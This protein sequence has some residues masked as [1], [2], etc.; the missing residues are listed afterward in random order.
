MRFAFV[1]LSGEQHAAVEGGAD[2]TAVP[3]STCSSLRLQLGA[4]ELKL[5]ETQAALQHARQR[6]DGQDF[7]AVVQGLKETIAAR[8]DQIT[9]LTVEV[10]E[11]SKQLSK[12]G[13]ELGNANN[14]LTSV[15]AACSELRKEFSKCSQSEACTSC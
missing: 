4:L 8:N 10:D 3:C 15:K 9:V 14:Q 13:E 6:Q 7:K 12:T 11:L 2:R 1:C 5:A